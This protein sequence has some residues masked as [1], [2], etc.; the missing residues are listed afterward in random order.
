M[1]MIVCICMTDE[2]Y[3]CTCVLM[4]CYYYFVLSITPHHLKWNKE[5]EPS[6][7]TRLFLDKRLQPSLIVTYLY[8]YLLI[9][10]PPK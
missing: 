7:F 2:Y 6:M 1:D 5:V 9:W 4:N 3:I 8:R 10:T